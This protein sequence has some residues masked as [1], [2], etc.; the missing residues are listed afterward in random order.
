MEIKKFNRFKKFV[1]RSILLQ[2]DK[3]LSHF[4]MSYL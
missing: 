1:E 3:A 2:N 4:A